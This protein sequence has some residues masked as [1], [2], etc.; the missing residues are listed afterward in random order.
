MKNMQ[1][2]IGRK[3]MAS[4]EGWDFERMSKT[5]SLQLLRNVLEGIGNCHAS[6]HH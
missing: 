2:N 6:H 1:V 3:K 4:S 5:S